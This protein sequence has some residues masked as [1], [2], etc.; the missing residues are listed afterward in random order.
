MNEPPY[1]KLDRTTFE[2][3][4][5]GDSNEVLGTPR[6]TDPEGETVT[7]ELKGMAHP[8]MVNGNELVATSSFDRESQD[9]YTVVSGWMVYWK[10]TQPFRLHIG[11]GRKPTNLDIDNEVYL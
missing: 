6:G 2:I 10:I 7:I 11:C 9:S 3:E 1:W 5:N 4:E 8:S